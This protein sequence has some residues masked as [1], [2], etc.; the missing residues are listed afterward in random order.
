VHTRKD[1]DTIVY[2]GPNTKPSVVSLIQ[3]YNRL[4]YKLEHICGVKE[5][6]YSGL[7]PAMSVLTRKATADKTSTESGFKQLQQIHTPTLAFH[8]TT[9]LLR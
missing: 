8:N 9:L 1:Y 5:D 6:L 4:W 2:R 3:C 7:A